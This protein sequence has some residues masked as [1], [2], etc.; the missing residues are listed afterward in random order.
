MKPKVYTRLIDYLQ[1][2]ITFYKVFIFKFLT[3]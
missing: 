1:I 2:L 3:S